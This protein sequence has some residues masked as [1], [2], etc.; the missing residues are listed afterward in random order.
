MHL[1]F[2]DLQ[3]PNYSGSTRFRQD[4][5]LDQAFF[6][7]VPTSFFVVDSR[8][9][10]VIRELITEAEGCAKM[11][12][13]TG[14]SAC[15]RKAIYE[16]LALQ[17][18]EGLNYDDKIKD[19]TSKQPAVDVELF[20]ILGHVKDMTSDHVHEQSWITWDTKHLQLFL[21]TFKAVLHEIYVVPDEKKNRADSVRVLR[22]Q[23]G[24]AKSDKGVPTTPATEN[25]EN[26]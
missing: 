2:Q 8:I 5:E 14:A 11:N 6:Y 22:E 3:D 18:A 23:L 12:Y 26:G 15:T 19:L 4:V 24:Q 21:E 20:E 1:T 10:R 13:L 25:P 17:E 16:L 7:S 9:P